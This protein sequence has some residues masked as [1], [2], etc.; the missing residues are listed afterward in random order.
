MCARY[1]GSMR[2]ICL[3]LTSVQELLPSFSSLVLDPFASHVIRALLLLLA[4][5]VLGAT[6]HAN[7]SS[8]A[9]SALRSKKS[10]AYKARQGS[11]K[12]VFTQGEAQGAQPI[13]STPKEFRKA[14]LRFVAALREQLGENEVRALAANQVASPV[15]QVCYRMDSS[16]LMLNN[17]LADDTR[18]RS[19]IWEGR[20]PRIHNGPCPG[21]ARHPDS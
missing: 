4:P 14:A 13:R 20:C 11:M 5:D 16:R 8:R 2:C 9:G 18:A 1:V 21:W 17:V 6:D 19:C 10:A 3:L 15:L 12:S 7:G